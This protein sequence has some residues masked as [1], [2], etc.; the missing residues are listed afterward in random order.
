MVPFIDIFGYLT[1]IYRGAKMRRRDE[2]ASNDI[3]FS[4]NLQQTPRVDAD[5]KI[6]FS[7]FSASSRHSINNADEGARSR[8]SCIR[9]LRDKMLRRR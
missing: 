2:L 1:L 5:H 9:L 6:I 3:S 4:N 8:Q 7:I